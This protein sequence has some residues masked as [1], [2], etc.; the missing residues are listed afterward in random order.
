MCAFKAGD[1]VRLPDGKETTVAF[2][3]DDGGVY[4]CV[5]RFPCERRD[6]ADLVNLGPSPLAQRPW[7]LAGDG[8]KQPKP[9]RYPSPW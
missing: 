6:P 7:P 9:W 5:T 2:V 1:R 8:S 4:V 3:A